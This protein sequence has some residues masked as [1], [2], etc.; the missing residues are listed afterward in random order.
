MMK[1]PATLV[2]TVA[3]ALT[4][5]LGA[6]GDHGALP[7]AAR[8]DA[9]FPDATIP[10]PVGE[11]PAGFLWGTAI[12]PY[13]VEG[14]LHASDWHQW[15]ARCEVCSGEHADDGPD[16]WNRY[17]D[18]L[19]N[20]AALHTGA[21]RLGIDWSRI[22]PTAASFPASPD[23]DA[24]RRYHDILAAARAHGLEPM[25]TLH[26]FVTPIWLHDL[27]PKTAKAGWED[28]AI[29]DAFAVWADFCAREF[30]AEVDWWITINEPL[31][32]V[33]GGYL[34][35]A[36]PPGA[37]LDIDR[38]ILVVMNMIEAHAR[39]YDALHA[40]DSVDADAD[41]APALVSIAQHMSAFRPA[42]PGDEE[43]ERATEMLRYLLNRIFLDAV[44]YGALDRNFDMD[45][46][47]AG[48]QVDPMLAG[49]LDYVGVNYYRLLL[50]AYI[51]ENNYPLIGL[52]FG[53]DLHQQGVDLPS[54]DFG[55]PIYAPGFREVLDEAAV[56]GLPIVITEN[57]LADGDDTLRP[58]FLLEHLYELARAIQDGLDI[59]GYY[60]WSLIDNFEWA[61]GYCPRFGLYHVDFESA[62][63]TRRAGEGAEVYRRI[64]DANTVPVELYGVYPRYPLPS[65]LCPRVG[66]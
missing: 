29:I 24:V 39:A 15:E 13:Q 46:D 33:A 44:V 47:D 2:A 3:L 31:A 57:G 37:G 58:R 53:N 41:G 52:P 65:T 17:E 27:E 43:S 23:L 4:T 19:A 26:H 16:F 62:D 11:F 9:G 50:G 59:R 34:S 54:T 64:I 22:F 66:L 49:R 56:Y 21:L 60:H 51:G 42:T 30:G 6:C 20:A 7:D 8:A 1:S 18:D 32:Y 40:G 48:E 25:V 45:T 12:A 61:S 38:G 5:A 10:P 55:W 35:G 14:G 28:P 63:R 36:F